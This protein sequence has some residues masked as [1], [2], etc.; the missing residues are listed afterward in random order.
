MKKKSK[1]NPDFLQHPPEFHD[2]T[3]VLTAS[4]AQSPPRPINI[5]TKI[6]RMKTAS[7]S[8]HA[9]R[10]YCYD[11]PVWETSILAQTRHLPPIKTNHKPIQDAALSVRWKY[12][13]G[14]LLCAAHSVLEQKH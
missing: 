5:T 13:S 2:A 12:H 6:T 1:N 4:D 9:L 11:K 7:M 14:A 10:F 3:C 8:H